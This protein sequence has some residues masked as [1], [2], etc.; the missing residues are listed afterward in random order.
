MPVPLQDE[1][2]SKQRAALLAGATVD[3]ATLKGKIPLF[4]ENQSLIKT[5]PVST[6]NAFDSLG[7]GQVP[8]QPPRVST[9]PAQPARD[10]G[11]LGDVNKFLP[12]FIT[13]PNFGQT[14]ISTG[15]FLGDV[16]GATPHEAGRSVGRA[17]ENTADIAGAAAGGLYG[18]GREFL[19]GVNGIP[20]GVRPTPSAPSEG[21]PKPKTAEELAKVASAQKKQATEAGAPDPYESMKASVPKEQHGLLD[22]LNKEFDL[23][24]VGLA[25]MATSGNGQDFGSNLGQA[26]LAGKADLA[27]KATAAKAER[28]QQI[29]NKVKASEV[30]KNIAQANKYLSEAAGT[31]KVPKITAELRAQAKLDLQAAVPGLKDNSTLDALAAQV[32]K[33]YAQLPSIG[34]RTPYLQSVIGSTVQGEDVI[35]DPW[36]GSTKVNPDALQ[37]MMQPQEITMG[38]LARRNELLRKQ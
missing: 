19:N 33:G 8:T 32:A 17:I 21:S 38:D 27:S 3:D 2:I 12:S 18:M 14:G 7:L 24:T 26:L 15:T 28:D 36:I 11:L 37:Y 23:V 30:M 16:L 20:E 5:A 31:N 9:Q 6:G 29:V 1:L 13:E 4:P 10:G 34:A 25:L 35:N 22:T